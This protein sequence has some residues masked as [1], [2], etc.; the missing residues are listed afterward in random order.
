MDL[1]IELYQILTI[2]EQKKNDLRSFV[3]KNTRIF[4]CHMDWLKFSSSENVI[5]LKNPN[6]W[7]ATAM[8]S[9]ELFSNLRPI[10][11]YIIFPHF[12]PTFTSYGST[13][14]LLEYFQNIRRKLNWCTHLGS[15]GLERLRVSWVG[16]KSLF[17]L[18]VLIWFFK[19][20]PLAEKAETCYTKPRSPVPPG[21]YKE[22]I[23]LLLI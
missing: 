11:I 2:Q 14:L 4:L 22:G 23:Y 21:L 17:I 7:T 19:L 20:I 13:W 9:S 18:H 10:V 12:S 1:K 16:C 5:F 15:S 8:Y 3:M 6:C